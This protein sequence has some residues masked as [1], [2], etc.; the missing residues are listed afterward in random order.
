MLQLTSVAMEAAISSF[1]DF[2]S[3][4]SE[5]G[6]H[7]GVPEELEHLD[8]RSGYRSRVEDAQVVVQLVLFRPRLPG[9]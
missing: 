7:G 2:I 6:M 8:V 1:I 5:S 9:S 3:S 4:A